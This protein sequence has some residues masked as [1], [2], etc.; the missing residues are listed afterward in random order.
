MKF[1]NRARI[2]ES[3]D[4]RVYVICTTRRVRQKRAKIGVFHCIKVQRTLTTEEQTQSAGLLERVFLR[5]SN[6]VHH[7]TATAVRLRAT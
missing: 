6:D 3:M 4:E 5:L 2:A 1:D 7:A